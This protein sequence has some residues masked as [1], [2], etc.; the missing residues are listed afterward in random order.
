MGD[1]GWGTDDVNE[2]PED[3]GAQEAGDDAPADNGWGD[4]PTDQPEPEPVGETETSAA[5]DGWGDIPADPPEATNDE[6]IHC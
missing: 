4:T 2:T 6:Y 5:G 3:A 1:M